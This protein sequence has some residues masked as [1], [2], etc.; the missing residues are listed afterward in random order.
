M[1]DPAVRASAAAVAELLDDDFMEYASSGG[2][3]DKAQVIEGLGGEAAVERSVT[4]LEVRQ[5][6]PDVA[7][8]TYRVTRHGEPPANSLRSSIWRNTGGQWRRLFHQGTVVSVD[9]ET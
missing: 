5:L 2:V 6:A 3:Y 7:L 4:D 8:V 1:L 9:P